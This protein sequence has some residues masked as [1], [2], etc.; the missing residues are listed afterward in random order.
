LSKK[1][2]VSRKRKW[3][4]KKPNFGSGTIWKYA[5][6]VGPAYLGATTHPGKKKEVR[7]YSKI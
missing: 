3:K 7:E 6:T 2:L 4:A 1:E 5:Q